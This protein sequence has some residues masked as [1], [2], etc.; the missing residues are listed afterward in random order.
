MDWD[1]AKRKSAAPAPKPASR[2]Q[3]DQRQKALA[4]FVAKHDLSCFKCGSSD[5]PWAKTGIGKSGLWAICVECT[6]KG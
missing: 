5:G 1:K 2:K 6:K 3:Q 4:E